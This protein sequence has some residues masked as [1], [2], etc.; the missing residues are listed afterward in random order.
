MKTLPPPLLNGTHRETCIEHLLEESSVH[1]ADWEQANERR[2]FGMV[3]PPWQRP[4]VWPVENQRRFIEGVFLGLGAGHHVVNGADF[5]DGTGEPKPMSGWLLDGQQRITAIRDFLDGKF[6]IF[7][8]IYKDD[9]AA[10]DL[11]RRFLRAKFVRVELEYTDDEQAL[12]ELYFRLAFSGVSH[13]EED[14][15]R[16]VQTPERARG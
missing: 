7:D 8:G 16:L 5:Y 1:R 13:T 9:L 4:E 6:A 10:I 12:K 15:E 2:L 11:R 3:L 14:L